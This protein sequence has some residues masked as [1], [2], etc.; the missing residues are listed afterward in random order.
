MRAAVAVAILAATTIATTGTV[1]ARDG[2]NS[3]NDVPIAHRD[4]FHAAVGFRAVVDPRT[5]DTDDD[6]DHLQV[7]HVDALDGGSARVIP[8]DHVGGGQVEYTPP[9]PQFTSIA[10]VR[11]TVSDG[12]GGVASEIVLIDYSQGPPEGGIFGLRSG[13]VPPYVLELSFNKAA[14]AEGVWSGTVDG[15]ATGTLTTVLIEQH[16]DGAISNV[17]FAWIISVGDQSFTADLSGTLNTETG[18]VVMDGTV[19]AGYLVGAEVHEEGQLVDADTLR[20]NG[21]IQLMAAGA[22]TTDAG[23]TSGVQIIDYVM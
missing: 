11:Y 10:S 12:H 17:R 4:L 22:L 15:D 6:G 2:G 1:V 5:N 8:L 14:V 16:A 20:F 18:A 9:S 23:G 3:V 7:V 21:T 13:E 19:V